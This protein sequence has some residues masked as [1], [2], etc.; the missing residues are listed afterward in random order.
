MPER[1][2]LP[3]LS[4][5]AHQKILDKYGPFII[6]DSHVNDPPIPGDWEIRISRRDD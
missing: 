1:Y 3:P 2:K 4:E 5:K 6:D